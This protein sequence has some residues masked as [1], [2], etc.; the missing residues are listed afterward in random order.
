MG[1]R[2]AAHHGGSGG[3]H[4]RL[5]PLRL[6]LVSLTSGGRVDKGGGCL[7]EPHFWLSSCGAGFTRSAG[8]GACGW[9]Q[10]GSPQHK[11][12]LKVGMGS[13]EQGSRANS[14]DTALLPPRGARWACWGRCFCTCSCR[15]SP[16]STHSCGACEALGYPYRAVQHVQQHFA[17]ASTAVAPWAAILT[18]QPTKPQR[19][20]CLM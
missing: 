9:R 4:F 3:K 1:A 20:P 15:P 10:C 6:C 8:R 13:R 16:A 2:L 5:V 17:A 18:K 11:S 12:R 14:P 7:V 19:S